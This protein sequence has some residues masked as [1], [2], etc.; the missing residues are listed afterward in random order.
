[1]NKPIVSLVGLVLALAA[2]ALA[3]GLVSA[4]QGTV[5]MRFVDYTRWPHGAKLRLTN[6][7]RTPIQY[8]AERDSTP[9]GSPL[10]R[11]Q[12]TPS[13]W[14]N[15]SVTVR[16]ALAWDSR[17]SKTTELFYIVDPAALPK[18]GDHLVT[19]LIRDLGPGQSAEFW[20]RLEPDAS[21][22]RFGTICCVP[23][24]KFALKLQPWLSRIK[25]WCRMKTMPPGQIEVWC[26]KPLY[27]TSSQQRATGN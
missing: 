18:P 13:G 14:T 10:L 11:L 20:V 17:T 24:S 12:K 5:S 16:S 26:P 21:P 7:T 22:M 15:A 25:Q 3:L 9:A 19:L 2:G 8:L 27:M 1:M 4:R 6:G 23:Q